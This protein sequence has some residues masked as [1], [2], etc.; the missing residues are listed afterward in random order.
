MITNCESLENAAQTAAAR[1]RIFPALFRSPVTGNLAGGRGP[2]R[3]EERRAVEDF[4]LEV[5]EIEIK[6]RRDE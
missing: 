5:L 2:G 3:T 6:H 1:W 4:F